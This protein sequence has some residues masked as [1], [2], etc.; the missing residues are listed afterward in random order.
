MT[1][2]E[3]LASVLADGGWHSTEEL[4][5]KVGHRFSASIH[6]LKQQGHRFEK[7]RSQGH[8]FEYRKIA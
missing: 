2:T 3:V 5:Q 6:L 4:V 7:R 8:Q 1:R